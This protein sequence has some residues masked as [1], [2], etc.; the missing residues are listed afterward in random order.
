M[1]GM[2]RDVDL[3]SKFFTNVRETALRR[4]AAALENSFANESGGQTRFPGLSSFC[5][6]AGN[7]P[8]YLY[9]WQQD[10]IAVSNSRVYRIDSNG[11]KTDVTGVPLGGDGRCIFA[12]TDNELC[13]AA[14]K[15]ILRLGGATTEILSDDAP[16]STHIG[17]IDGYLLAIEPYSGRF[18]HCGVDDF[19]TWSPLD[20]F[21]ADAKPD[22]LNGLIIT[23]FREVILSGID[24]VEQFERL[25]SGSVP[26]YRRWANG[27]GILAPYTLTLED[28]GVWGV[29]KDMEFVRLTG[30]TSKSKSDDI[31]RS[32]AA[33]DDWRLAWAQPLKVVGQTFIVLQM[34][35]ATNKYGTQGVTLLYDLRQQKWFELYDW[36][37]TAAKPARWPGW[38]VH[39]LWGRHFV[40]GNGKVLELEE[41]AY[42][43]D[44]NMQRMLGRT[45]HIDKWGNSEI[46]DVRI[47]LHRG[48]AAQNATEPKFRFR[49]LR[50]NRRY[51]KWIERSLGGPGDTNLTIE[52]GPLGVAMT[53][54]FEW[55]ITDDVPVD[56]TQM[57]VLVESSEQA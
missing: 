39:Q 21:T 56:L 50:D 53:W 23:P 8:T 25:T 14:G 48:A 12:K 33:I 37:A 9:D 24:S 20:V 31:G 19:R 10:L 2:W 4:A 35:F 57:Q 18:Q 38:S 45:A 26:F 51:T 6:L 11:V 40:G 54:Q 42:T 1:P 7:N 47:R 30:Q 55:E 5:T 3:A 36:D 15:Q 46:H 13:M 32:L 17:Y 22:D 44:G 43:N 52:L 49:A 28:Q 34:P 16:D 41:T 27:F 29:N